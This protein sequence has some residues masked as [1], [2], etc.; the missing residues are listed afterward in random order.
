MARWN[1][2]CDYAKLAEGTP[3]PRI[4]AETVEVDGETHIV[5]TAERRRR[6][7]VD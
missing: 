5:Q 7:N 6:I 4:A 2:L 3:A 1:R